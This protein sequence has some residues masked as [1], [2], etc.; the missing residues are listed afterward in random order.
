MDYIEKWILITKKTH[1]SSPAFSVSKQIIDRRAQFAVQ[2]ITSETLTIYLT[3]GSTSLG[4]GSDT[5][6]LTDNS[7]SN[8]AG[9]TINPGETEILYS[10]L[11]DTTVAAINY[12]TASDNIG[13]Q[14]FTFPL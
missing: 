3:I 4:T 8:A 1:I 12:T 13:D 14:V 9:I 5:Y 10:D 7:G 6:N 2:N 11:L